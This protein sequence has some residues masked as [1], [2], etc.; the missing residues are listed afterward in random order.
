MF[1]R[2]R[3]SLNLA[4]FDQVVRQHCDRGV[5]PRETETSKAEHI[6]FGQTVGRKTDEKATVTDHVTRLLFLAGRDG[7]R[8]RATEA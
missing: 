8:I 2:V 6:S 5:R 7:D 1:I 4:H 3:G